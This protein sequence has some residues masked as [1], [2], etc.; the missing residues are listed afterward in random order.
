MLPE[1]TRQPPKRQYAIILAGGDGTRLR[2][3]TS[4][5][6]GD[7]RPKQFCPLLGQETLFEQTRKRVE[8][9]IPFE[10]TTVI[11]THGHEP[12]FTGVADTGADNVLIQPRNRGTAPALLYALLRL[13]CGAPNRSVAVFPSDH[14]VSDGEAFMT[15][16]AL[17]F[18]ASNVLPDSVVLLGVK[19]SSPETGYGWIEPGEELLGSSRG[20]LFR[21]SK[22]WEKPRRELALQLWSR[23]ALWNSFVMVGKVATLVNL[24]RKTAPELYGSFAHVHAALGTDDEAEC[25]EE[26]Y[27]GLDTID[28]SRAVLSAVVGNLAVMPVHGVEWSDIGEPHRVLSAL[29]RASIRPEWLSKADRDA[30][31]PH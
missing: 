16:V 26:I 25:M 30:M 12:Y 11:L 9:L 27:S 15:H 21:V 22:F 29:R 18:Q 7:N 13:S 3:L 4:K 14:Y 28:F 6:S 1:K 31:E 10:N 20:K 24:I 19:A 23:G 17:A 8:F 5:I 2:A